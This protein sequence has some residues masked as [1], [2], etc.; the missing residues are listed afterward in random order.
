VDGASC[1]DLAGRPDGLLITLEDR[2]SEEQAQLLPHITEAGE[3]GLALEDITE[4]SPR[5]GLPSSARNGTTGQ[6][7]PAG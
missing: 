5:T 4:H 2:L 6:R 3:Y 1:E 7:W